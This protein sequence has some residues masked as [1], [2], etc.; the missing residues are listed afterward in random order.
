M[1]GVLFGEKH[2]YRDWGL[3][4]KSRP[5]ISSP[6]VKTNYIDIPASDSQLDL[7]ESLTGEVT[8]EDRLLNCEFVVTQSRKKW[9]EI[10]S[11]ILD[12]LHGK[13]MK[14]I[15]DEDLGYY[16]EG[17]LEVD[18]WESDKVTSKIV[19]KGLLYPYKHDRVSTIE[20]WL[21]DAFNFETGIIRDYR[22]I[23]V[24]DYLSMIIEGNREPS[25]PSFIVQNSNNLLVRFDD[26][27]YELTNGTNK[28]VD[29]R[30][31]EGKNTLIFTGNGT[32]SID[33]KGGRL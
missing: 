1:N 21:W 18:E 27:N 2:S 33:Y 4:L 32:V 20:D 31:K 7:T 13:R 19:I 25:I 28:I 14:I 17:R 22:N 30:L 11:E 29:I 5:V 6:K 15:L 3:L 9:S 10:Y 16:Y 8:Y 24:S 12:Y 26:K 23:K